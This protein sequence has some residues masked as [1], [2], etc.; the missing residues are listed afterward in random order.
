M[1]LKE[2]IY[3]DLKDRMKPDAILASNTSSLS[4]D[5]LAGPSPD[6]TRFAGLHFFNPVSRI[7]LVEVVRGAKT[8]SETATRLAA[9]CGAS[10]NCPRWSTITPG[11]S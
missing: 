5:T 7:D 10:A 3:S 11:L 2:K 9:F 6:K 1:E 4:V 8:S